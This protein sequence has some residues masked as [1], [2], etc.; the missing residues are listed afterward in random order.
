MAP[1]Q[2]NIT[3]FFP[4]QR[5]GLDHG[6]RAGRRKHLSRSEEAKPCTCTTKPATKA[7]KVLN[8]EK[9]Y[10]E[11]F[12]GLVDSLVAEICPDLKKEK[13]I[14]I[15][16]RCPICLDH[17][18]KDKVILIVQCAHIKNKKKKSQNETF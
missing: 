17:L 16:G 9:V 4:Q 12:L 11:I 10:E 5:K 18:E 6:I 1:Q 7:V 8:K 3:E 15:L 13:E 2:R 14:L